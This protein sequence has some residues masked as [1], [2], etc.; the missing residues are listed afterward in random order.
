VYVA[1]C[2]CIVSVHVCEVYLQISNAD[3]QKA[4]QAHL[5]LLKTLSRSGSVELVDTVPAGICVSVAAGSDTTLHVDI[6]V[7]APVI[8]DYCDGSRQ[9]F[10]Y[11]YKDSSSSHCE[12]H[13]RGK[14]D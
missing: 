14:S 5:L 1:I 2:R 7:S 9:S 11:D 6:A 10:M 13:I 4:V 3:F 12:H 8:N